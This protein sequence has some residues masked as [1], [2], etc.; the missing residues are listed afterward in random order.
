M[1]RNYDG[2]ECT[3]D[4]CTNRVTCA[5]FDDDKCVNHSYNGNGIGY[6]EVMDDEDDELPPKRIFKYEIADTEVTH[7][8]P[9]WSRAIHVATQEGSP[10]VWMLVD[11]TATKVSMKFFV[12]PTGLEDVPANSE[13]V[14]TAHNVANLGLVFHIFLEHPYGKSK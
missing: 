9:A 3:T 4:D 2:G 13:Y 10:C 14:G 6:C 5:D 12:V 8:V 1:C 11:P 7:Q